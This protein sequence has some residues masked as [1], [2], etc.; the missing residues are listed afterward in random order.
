M[1]TDYKRRA[2]LVI[3]HS[4]GCLAGLHAGTHA[5]MRHR[6]SGRRRPAGRT[7][8]RSRKS[9]CISSLTFVVNEVDRVRRVQFQ[10]YHFALAG[11]QFAPQDAQKT[12]LWKERKKGLTRLKKVPFA[13]QATIGVKQTL[14]PAKKLTY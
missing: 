3:Y 12:L 5:C 7:D 14:P 4:L 9:L 10:R 11:G 6:V 2:R 1:M 8:C 13:A